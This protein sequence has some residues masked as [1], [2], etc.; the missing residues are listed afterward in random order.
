MALNLPMRSANKPGMNLP[1]ALPTFKNVMSMGAEAEEV[2]PDWTAKE[3]RYTMGI[4]RPHSMKKT[5]AVVHANDA[6]RKMRRSGKYD[7]NPRG[8]CA[9]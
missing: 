9:E 8:F 1:T 7:A 2:A 4:K 6:R 3:A 5:P